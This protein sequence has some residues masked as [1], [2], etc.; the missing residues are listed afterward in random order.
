MAQPQPSGAQEYKTSDLYY[1]AYLKVAGVPFLEPERDGRRVTFVFE[2]SDSIRDLKREYF[3]R[4]A[5][6]PA[7]TY[8]DEVKAMKALTHMGV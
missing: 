1:A 3:N 4:N 6:V 2:H 8:A 7:L 5:K